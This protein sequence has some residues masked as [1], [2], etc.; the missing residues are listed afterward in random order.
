[1]TLD[2]ARALWPEIKSLS[3]LASEEFCESYNVTTSTAEICVRDEMSGEVEPI[4]HI[5]PACAYDDRRLLIKSPIL[6]QAAR[7]LIEEASRRLKAAEPPTRAAPKQKR[8]R[9]V[10]EACGRMC[11]DASFLRF[12]AVCHNV[13]IADRERVANRV[14]TMINVESRSQLDTD[15]LAR[16]RW[17]SLCDE[18]RDWQK[19][20]AK[21]E[22]GGQPDE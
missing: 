12:L 15:E 20:I 11:N 17:F 4:A 9:T 8:Q 21:G 2:D 18:F 7:I 14:R 3:S 16:K 1:M 22:P 6:L 13:D 10:A 5:L 19:G